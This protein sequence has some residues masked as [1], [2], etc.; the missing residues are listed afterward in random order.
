[1]N[2]ETITPP[3]KRRRWFQFRLRTLFVAFTVVA[4]V[5]GLVIHYRVHLVWCYAAWH[6]GLN[7]VQALP[8]TSMP[9]AKVPNDWVTCRFGSLQFT[10]PPGMQRNSERV[11]S[12]VA[13]LVL[14]DGARTMVV[15]LPEDQTDMLHL[16]HTG[17]K[18]PPEGQDLS[19]VMLRLVC[20]QSGSDEFRWSMSPPEV[21]W[22]AWRVLTGQLMRVGS[23]RAETVLQEDLQGVAYFHANWIHFEW[24]ANSDQSGGYIRFTSRSEEQQTDPAWIRA[25]CRSVTCTGE[26]FPSRMSKDEV[27]ALFEIIAE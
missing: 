10:M 23:V 25:V 21:R 2:G 6:Q 7:D 20:R 15:D 14:S 11:P 19:S 13:M 3:K 12:G 4:L 22:F 27:E 1:M 9:E 16:L 24:Q 8:V 5:L 17:L 18:M 26:R